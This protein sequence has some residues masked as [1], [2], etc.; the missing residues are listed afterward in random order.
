M[1]SRHSKSEAQRKRSLALKFRKGAPLN[2]PV[3]VMLEIAAG[4]FM[5]WNDRPMHP[6]FVDCM[7]LRT[8]KR[9]VLR[10]IV[11]KA[12]L[13]SDNSPMMLPFGEDS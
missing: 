2:S 1:K 8:I 7:T 3:D 5:I 4:R 13:R 12:E 11:F 9:A 6:S 10:G